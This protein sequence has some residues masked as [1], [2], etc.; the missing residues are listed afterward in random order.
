MRKQ[1]K[2]EIHYRISGKA[3]RSLVDYQTEH[4]ILSESVALNQ[5]LCRRKEQLNGM[6]A[7]TEKLDKVASALDKQYRSSRETDKNVQI[8][9]EMLNAVAAVLG[10]E[11]LAETDGDSL[12][13]YQSAKAQVSSTIKQNYLRRQSQTKKKT[14]SQSE[15]EKKPET[16]DEYY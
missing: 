8:L 1:E 3:Y 6:E 13:L 7:L 14:E 12:S 15:Q 4:E 5:L 10:V 11:E 9:L 16:E 2:V